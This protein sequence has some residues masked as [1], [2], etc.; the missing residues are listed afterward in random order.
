MKKNINLVVT[1]NQVEKIAAVS[2]LCLNSRSDD[3]IT[4]EL[5]NTVNYI[6]TLSEINTENV[7]PTFQTSCLENIYRDDEIEPGLSQKSALAN[8]KR[9]HNGYFVSK[10]V[11]E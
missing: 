10:S 6:G 1:K 2:H 3:K 11:F 7:L 5:N 8:A 9:T 4:M